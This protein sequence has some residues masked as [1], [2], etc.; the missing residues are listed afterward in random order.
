MLKEITIPSIYTGK[1]S[2][3]NDIVGVI[4]ENFTYLEDLIQSMPSDSVTF[5]KHV[6]DFESYNI[7]LYFSENK[8]R[9]DIS[10]LNNIITVKI[11]SNEIKI[12]ADGNII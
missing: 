8:N 2:E 12:D 11:G 4:N 3:E 6:V 5:E 9:A 7:S 1:I 10:V